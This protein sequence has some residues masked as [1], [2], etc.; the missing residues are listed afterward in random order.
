MEHL[1]LNDYIVQGGGHRKIRGGAVGASGKTV[2]IAIAVAVII[3]III[4]VIWL[5]RRHDKSKSGFASSQI[6][7]ACRGDADCLTIANGCNAAATQLMASAQLARSG[8]PPAAV[9]APLNVSDIRA[10]TKAV[11]SVPPASANRFISSMGGVCV[12]PSVRQAQQQVRSLAADKPS[13]MKLGGIVQ[14]AAP[15]IPYAQKLSS[16]WPTCAPRYEMRAAG[17]NVPT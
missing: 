17:P 7:A 2:G 9:L 16:T 1:D 8:A 10:C 3:L 11:L 15:L 13:L 12:P 5:V 14:A 6:A 4:L